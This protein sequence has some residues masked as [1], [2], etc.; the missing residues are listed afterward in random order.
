M[1]LESPSPTFPIGKEAIVLYGLM[2]PLILGI[3]A[4]YQRRYLIIN[5]DNG[6]NSTKYN[7][8]SYH[9]LVYLLFMVCLISEKDARLDIS[10]S[11]PVFIT[12]IKDSFL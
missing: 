4:K 10:K 7:C 1:V 2:F 5:T 11:K 8:N 3:T 9:Y 12:Y 6:E